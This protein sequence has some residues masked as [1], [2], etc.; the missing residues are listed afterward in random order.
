MIEASEI[1]IRPAKDEDA[2]PVCDLLRDLGLTLPPKSEQQKVMAH[3]QRMWNNNPF[4][5]AYN[6][7]VFYGWVMEHNNEIVGF[8]GTVPR[9]YYLQGQQLPVSIASN[10][11]VKKEYR[12]FTS[13]LCDAYF[14]ANPMP[15]KLV[16][17]AIK[18]TGKIFERYN[19]KRAPDESLDSVYIVPYNLPKLMALKFS[20]SKLSFLAPLAKMF[21]VIPIWNLPFRF[22]RDKRLEE[23]DV[24]NMPADYSVFIDSYIK[25]SN[26]FMA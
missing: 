18:P 3:W 8:F 14:N 17:T 1:I 11:G 20:K 13:M 23:V 26:A 15:M 22:A 10:W 5:K 16:T 6:E 19:G 9:I 2:I 25:T 21:S 4:Y 24:F 12:A 7:P